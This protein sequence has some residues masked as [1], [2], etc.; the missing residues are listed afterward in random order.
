[1]IENIMLALGLK[2]IALLLIIPGW[3]T[4]WLAIIADMGATLLVVLNA[5]RLAR[6]YK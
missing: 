3:L 5:L 2:V 1:M 6:T 4:L